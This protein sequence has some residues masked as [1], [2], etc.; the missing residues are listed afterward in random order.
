MKSGDVPDDWFRSSEAVPTAFGWQDAITCMSLNAPEAIERFEAKAGVNEVRQPPNFS[1]LTSIL[2]CRVRARRR[3]LLSNC[4]CYY[5]IM[6]MWQRH[7]LFS[8]GL[9]SGEAGA[10]RAERVQLWATRL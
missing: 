2:F 7:V 4:G 6:K 3:S 8:L 9:D 10:H 1:A 5:P